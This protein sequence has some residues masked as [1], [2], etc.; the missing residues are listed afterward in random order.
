MIVKAFGYSPC[1]EG[2]G[3]ITRQENLDIRASTEER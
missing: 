2:H 1:K 3:T